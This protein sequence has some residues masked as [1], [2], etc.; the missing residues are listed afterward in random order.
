MD[1]V[2]RTIRTLAPE[3]IRRGQYVSILHVVVQVLPTLCAEDVRWGKVELLNIE[4]LPQ[5]VEPMKVI[6]VC[7]PFVLVR[8][9]SGRHR[10][11]DVRRY[12]LA[13][14]DERFG[15]KV[16]KRLRTVAAAGTTSSTSV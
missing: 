8:R 6:E 10:M 14:V 7:L 11:I 3:D 15:R 13:E 9:V 4:C 12:R 2:E 5:K 1:V 16:F